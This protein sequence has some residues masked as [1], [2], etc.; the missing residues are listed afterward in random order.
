MGYGT[1]RHRAHAGQMEELF[2]NGHETR[3]FTH[4]RPLTY[5]MF[6][7]AFS[8][9]PTRR[10]SWVT[11]ATSRC[12]LPCSGYLKPTSGVG[13]LPSFTRRKCIS[14][15]CD[16]SNSF[17]RLCPSAW[18]TADFPC[19]RVGHSRM[20]GPGPARPLYSALHVDSNLCLL[21]WPAR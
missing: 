9:L 15:N 14:D 20:P 2:V 11:H 1:V 21:T 5:E 18:E 13:G 8:P 7:A 10:L 16:L 12:A 19:G 17:V 6:W 3:T 4:T